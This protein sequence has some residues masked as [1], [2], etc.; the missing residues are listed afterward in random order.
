MKSIFIGKR[1]SDITGSSE[2]KKKISSNH[3]VS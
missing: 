3:T 1:K 2:I